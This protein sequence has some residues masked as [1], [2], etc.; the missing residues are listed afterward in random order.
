MGLGYLEHPYLSVRETVIHEADLREL[1]E[2]SRTE[3]ALHKRYSPI[4]IHPC[5]LPFPMF[6]KG[7]R[8]VCIKTDD[9][10]A[11][12]AHVGQV[13][14]VAEDSSGGNGTMV[15]FDIPDLNK[16]TDGRIYP[17]IGFL[18]SSLRKLEQG[19]HLQVVRSKRKH[20]RKVATE[21]AESE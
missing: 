13:A 4:I 20:Q 10:M 14:T 6:E 8:V 7:D 21:Q 18:S 11:T 17:V 9:H 16:G 12:E 5:P 1:M 2:Y 15:T 19:E 3:T